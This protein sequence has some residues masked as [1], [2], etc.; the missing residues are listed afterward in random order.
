MAEPVSVTT[1]I[2][3]SPQVVYDL[4]SDLPGMG[5]LSPENTGGKWLKDATGPAVGA[6]FK[7]TNRRGARRWS[8][9]CT[10]AE[11]T[12]GEVFTFDVT[13]GPAKVAR[14]SYRITPTADGCDVTETWVDHRPGWMGIVGNLASGVKDRAPHN[15]AG[16]R[17]TL[18]NVKAAAEAS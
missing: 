13:A 2:N 3:A 9:T 12:P 8:T 5:K 18:A 11:A 1:H 14:W 17:E 4:V 16:M 15:E 10:I 6:R 7:G